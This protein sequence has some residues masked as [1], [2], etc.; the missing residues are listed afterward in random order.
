MNLATFK[1]GAILRKRRGLLGESEA[2]RLCKGATAGAL[3]G[4][5]GSW[6]MNLFQ[7]ILGKLSSKRS[8]SSQQGEQ[9]EPQQYGESSQDH[10]HGDEPATAVLAEKISTGVLHHRLTEREK[11]IAEPALH[12]G[13]GT[14]MGAVYGALAEETPAITACTGTLYGTALWLLGD[15]IAVPLLKLS[16]PPMKY[17]VSIHISALTS[18][19]VYGL[20]AE[21]VRR[22]VRRSL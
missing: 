11:K 6:T 8:R 10:P 4:L 12:Y 1:P 22:T 17:P 21:A 9:S 18:H 16:K 13:Y 19:L 7:A 14:M 3:G 20:T 15:E 5:A 2:A